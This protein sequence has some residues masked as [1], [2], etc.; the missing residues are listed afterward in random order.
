MSSATTSLTTPVVADLA[1][2][3]VADAGP[4]FVIHANQDWT[5]SIKGRRFEPDE[6]G[7]H[8]NEERRQA[9]RRPQVVSRS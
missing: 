4:S 2:G 7:L 5:M 8:R 1:T 9:D 3:Y 6:L